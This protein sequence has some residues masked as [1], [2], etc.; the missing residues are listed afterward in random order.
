M[1]FFKKKTGYDVKITEIGNK[2]PSISGL[3]TIS[4]STAVDNKIPNV[5]SR[6]YKNCNT[7]II[8]Q[9]SVKLEKKL[10]TMIMINTP[11]LQ[12]LIS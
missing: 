2:I 4:A 10:L 11:L 6:N 1:D 9:K 7:R 12:S 3:A 5:S 8:T